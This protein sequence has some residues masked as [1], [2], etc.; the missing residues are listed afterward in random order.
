MIKILRHHRVDL[1]RRHALLD[2][3]LHAQQTDAILVLHQ[4][5][6]GANATVAEMI[7]VVDLALAV[8]QIDKRLHDREDVLAAK[9]AHRIGRVELE[10]HVHLDATNRRKIEPLRIEEQA[11]EQRRRRLDRRRLAGTHHPVDV[12]QRFLLIGILVDVERIADE[13]ADIDVVNVEDVEFLDLLSLQF[14]Q[15]FS[16]ELIAGFGEDLTRFEIDD[17]F[18]DEAAGEIFRRDQ[19]FLDAAF[20]RSLARAAP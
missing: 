1:D 17:V 5:A 13:R 6:D 15:Q 20:R 9:H 10:T 7:D 8:A 18:R 14:G 2:G 4:L 19:D 3:A 12:H 11:L 16:V